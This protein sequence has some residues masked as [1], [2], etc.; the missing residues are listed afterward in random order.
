VRALC[1]ILASLVLLALLGQP[2]AAQAPAG[3]RLGEVRADDA[4]LWAELP[5]PPRAVGGTADAPLCAEIS[6]GVR[7]TIVVRGREGWAVVDGVIVIDRRTRVWLPMVR[8]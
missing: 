7:C 2:A 3:W 5:A 4:W 6:G 1:P 8:R